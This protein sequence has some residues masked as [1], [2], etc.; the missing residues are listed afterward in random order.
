MQFTKLQGAGND[1]IFVDGLSQQRDWSELSRRVSDRHFG[2]GSDGLIVAARSER[3]DI[4]MRM[5]NADGSESEMCGN[6]IRCFAKFVLERGLVA[7]PDGA[8][9][10]ET[11]AGL[12]AV[13][14]SWE[15]GR[16]TG[17][18]VDM[19]APVLRA[20]DVP[21]DPGAFGPSDYAKLDGGIIEALGLAPDDLVFDAP[22]TL[23]LSPEGRG[24]GTNGTALVGSAVS[25][26]N[27]HFVALLDGPVA[28]VALE[29]SGP[30]VEHHAAFPNRVNFTVA[31]VE[32]RGRIVS[33]TWERGSGETMACGT[34]VCATV[35]AARLHGLVDDLVSVRVPG[36]E[37]TITW[38]GHGPVIMEGDAVEVFSGEWP[39]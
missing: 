11:G 38:P 18:L 19:G 13:T 9:S 14:P 6:G 3:A 17:A 33:R 15:G 23:T 2:I 31:N 20:A 22:L 28:G 8:L 25:M 37:L 29:R 39:D 12:I 16:I 32:S 35:V 1:Y 30:L 27:P 4:R 21:A 7:A 24:E 34:G 5:W 36:G 26:G 10:V